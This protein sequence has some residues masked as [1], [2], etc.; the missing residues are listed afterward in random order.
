MTKDTPELL[1]PLTRRSRR[2]G[3]APAA[4]SKAGRDLKAAI[5]IGLLLAALAVGSLLILRELF[6]VLWTGIFLV[7]ALFLLGVIRLTGERGEIGPVRLVFGL[8]TMLFSLYCGYGALG[9]EMDSVMTA[10]IPNYS[11]AS[12][13]TASLGTGGTRANAAH[14]IIKDDYE[15]ALARA[16]D[17]NRLVLVNFTGFT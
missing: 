8:L 5:G 13:G 3:G 1:P 17:E 16:R 12:V 6:L 4:P 14:V 2:R 9:R 10:I 7:A 15:A 11:H